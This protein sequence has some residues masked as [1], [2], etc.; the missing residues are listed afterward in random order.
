M[1]RPAAS[2]IAVPQVEEVATQEVAEVSTATPE[3]IRRVVFEC[4]AR[5]SDLANGVVVNIQ[6]ASHVFAPH[7]SS[8]LAAEEKAALELKKERAIGR[9]QAGLRAVHMTHRSNAR[10]RDQQHLAGP[11]FLGHFPKPI[12]RAIAKHQPQMQLSIE[13]GL[14]GEFGWVAHRWIGRRR[15]RWCSIRPPC[16][17]SVVCRETQTCCLHAADPMKFSWW[18]LAQDSDVQSAGRR[19]GSLETLHCS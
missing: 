8:D 19:A 3:L 4:N 9:R 2:A 5:G 12:E 10:I 6:N 1:S 14:V 17:W 15:S 16:Q 11:V 13:A 18:K 7:I